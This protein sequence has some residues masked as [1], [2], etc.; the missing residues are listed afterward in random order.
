[1]NIL[2]KIVVLLTRNLTK[3]GLHFSVFSTIFYA[4]SMLQ[5]NWNYYLRSTL[6]QG[7][8]NFSIPYIYALDLQKWPWKDQKCCNVALGHGEA[9]GSP[10]SGGSSGVLG[11]G[12]V[13]E[14]GE[15]TGDR[16]ATGVSTITPTTSAADGGGRRWPL[17]LGVRRGSTESAATHEG[18]SSC[19]V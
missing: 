17:R 8:W 16:F 14:E 9:A 2:Y 7:P 11:R 18:L 3:L 12:N 19:G 6:Y 15:L 4:F 1:M 5:Q 13:R 10:E